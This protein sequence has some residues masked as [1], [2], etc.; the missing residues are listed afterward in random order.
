MALATLGSDFRTHTQIVGTGALNEGRLQGDLVLVGAATTACRIEFFPTPKRWNAR[1]RRKRL[2]RS[3]VDQVVSRG[4]K[5]VAGDVIATIAILTVAD[6]RRAGPWTTT[7]WSYG[8][9]AGGHRR[10]RQ[11]P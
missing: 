8:A 3:W 9:A 5:E 10:G 4:V 6:S 1:A 11:P 2:W 7:V